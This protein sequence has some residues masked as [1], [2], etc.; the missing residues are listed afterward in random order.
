MLFYAVY[1]LIWILVTLIMVWRS[2][3]K[4]DGWAIV[5]CSAFIGFI[6]LLFASIGVSKMGDED[7][8]V[9]ESRSNL[10]AVADNS[11]TSGSFLVFGTKNYYQYYRATG[12]DSFVQGSVAI[13]ETT[14]VEDAPKGQGYLQVMKDT[15]CGAFE[16]LK[17]VDC[18]MDTFELHI[19]PG[20]IVRDYNLDLND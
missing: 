10:V 1:I 16:P 2:S 13:S 9:E 15:Q 17:P 19:P 11:G 6:I 12:K 20:S 18:D 3:G 14:I 7:H 8:Y 5:G 4:G